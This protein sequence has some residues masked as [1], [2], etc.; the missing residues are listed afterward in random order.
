LTINTATSSTSNVTICASSGAYSWNGNS[1]SSS[2]S[3]TFST[4]NANGCDSTAILNLTVTSYLATPAA[5][6]TQPTCASATGTIIVTTPIGDGITYSI[7][8]AYQSSPVFSGVTAGTY[9]VSVQSGAGCTSAANGSA[10]VNAQPQVPGTVSV[11]GLTNVC[12]IIGTVTTTTYTATASGA[13]GYTWTV[14]ANTVLV[15]GQGTATI[16]VRFLSGFATQPNKQIRVTATSSC[17]S[18]AQKIYYLSAQLPGTPSPIV[19]ST[20]NVCPSIGTGVAITYRIAKVMG[21][22]S[23]IWTAQNGTTNVTNVN[24]AG[25]NDTLIAVTFENNF[26]SSN[27]TVQ[28]V[29]DCGV[30]GIRSLTVFRNNPSTPGLIS[31]PANAC[32]YI[33]E[34][35]VN[36]TYT[37]TA[38]ASVVSY[39]W[40][41]PQGATNVSGQGTNSISFRYPAGYTGGSISVTAS[42][43]CGT[44]GTRSLSIA[45]LAP[46]YPG[47]IDVINLSACP[48]RSYSYTVSGLPSNAT[49]LQWTVPAGGTIVSGQGTNSIVVNYGSG[50]V[51]GN[52]SVVAVNN[53]GSSLPRNSNVK[54]SAC[55]SGFAGNTG[56]KALTLNTEEPLQTALFPNPSASSFHLQL[57]GNNQEAVS[58]R[59]LDAQGRV[60]KSYREAAIGTIQ[61]GNDLKAGVYMV[62]VKQGN[63]VKT[64]RVVKY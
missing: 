31:G 63:A 32:A 50:V 57:K 41:I 56:N 18:S 13:T 24:G 14:P 21:A 17:G 2:G 51:N 9:A 29:N 54:L 1:Y 19:A 30:S 45:V 49:S 62:E 60:V 35:G 5:S 7:G 46:S 38:N 15:S 61:F 28:S 43:G 10:T 40:T 52:V 59:V 36:A 42:N 23:Y 47:Q 11:S 4:T 58:I 48:N 37:V 33:G 12:A 44:S 16:T 22:A 8:G 55:P 26:S 6:V 39:T 27:I 25:E 64:T 20:S 34:T 53:C 3:Y